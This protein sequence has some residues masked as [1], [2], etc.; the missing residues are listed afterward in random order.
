MNLM[1]IRS[2]DQERGIIRNVAT[3]KTIQ[4]PNRFELLGISQQQS[5][6]A[7][8]WFNE[9][10]YPAVYSQF[11]FELQHIEVSLAANCSSCL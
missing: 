10:I 5:D 3:D 7:S 1:Q 11:E 4:G 8:K 2:I 6:A 9:T